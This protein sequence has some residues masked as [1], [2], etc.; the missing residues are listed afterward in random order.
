MVSGVKQYLLRKANKHF[1]FTKGKKYD[2]IIIDDL[3]PVPLS[4][5]RNH[6]YESLLKTY[7]SSKVILDFGS[8]NGMK[9]DTSYDEHLGKLRTKYPV[10]ADKLVPIRTGNSINAKLFYTIFYQN[11]RK[12]YRVLNSKKIN[13]GFT[14][15]PGGGFRFDDAALNA[16]L[17]EIISNDLC[18][19]VIVNQKITQDYLVD[20]LKIKKEKIHLV[21]GIPLTHVN[22]QGGLDESRKFYSG[23]KDVIDIV[24]MAHKYAAFG[25]DKGF[26]VFQNT[27]LDLNDDKL[28]K[29][30]VVGNFTK[31]DL[32]Y[33]E[34]AERI[35]FHGHIP[36]ETFSEFFADK[37][38]I[39]SPN[40]PH[41]FGKGS[42]DGFPL[43]SSIAGG[44]NGCV[45]LLTNYFNESPEIFID[46]THY[47]KV[48]PSHKQIA[49]RITELRNNRQRM[50]E[51][52]GNGR[53]KILSVYYGKEQIED[54]ID[55]FNKIL[56]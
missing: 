43:G 41:M 11:I 13:F 42:F 33:P 36:E 18:K 2:L 17:Q 27:A 16:H 24:F 20:V 50:R 51:L 40:R 35:S 47:L 48:R 15:Y 28:Y 7:S 34:L 39:I 56:Q 5:W 21:Y 49:G 26:D 3:L 30:H 29:F 4:P 55:I 25:M 32:L 44:V 23:S 53:N 6:E 38:I 52:A 8:Y 46:E 19:F 9:G 12:Y 31:E 54:R 14:L 37:D 1:L 45:M 22:G 10:L